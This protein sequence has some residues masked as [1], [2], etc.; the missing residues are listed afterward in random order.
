M[1]TKKNKTILS[2]PPLPARS[3]QTNL[4]LVILSICT[5]L[6]FSACRSHQ[7]AIDEPSPSR[8]PLAFKGIAVLAKGSNHSPPHEIYTIAGTSPGVTGQMWQNM[9]TWRQESVQYAEKYR[10]DLYINNDPADLKV[11]LTFDDGPDTEN[12]LKIMNTLLEYN[13][14]ATF[15]FTGQSM[16][17]HP[18]IVRQIHRN[19]FS[20]G[21]HGLDHSRF[22]LMSESDLRLQ[23]EQSNNI[24][25]TLTGTTTDFTRPPY[26]DINDTVIQNLATLNQKTYLWSIDTLDWAQKDPTAI[27]RNIQDNL[28][29]GDI[30]LMH[31]SYG[32]PLSAQILPEIITYIRA[33]GY[34]LAALP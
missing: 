14:P 8:T 16:S 18:D 26:G 32:Q 11:Y 4:I 30:I 33:Q 20:I 23:I 6:F 2:A 19:G 27:L 13:A 3:W 22:T 31:C 7:P 12:T 24:L 10:G 21:L 28:R 9:L 15:F 5:C 34:E 1:N 25:Y 17:G 29:P